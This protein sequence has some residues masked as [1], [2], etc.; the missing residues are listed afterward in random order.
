M[1]AFM[2]SKFLAIV[3]VLIMI[4][5]VNSFVSA[6]QYVIAFSVKTLTNETF[7][8]A[9]ADG[10]K[11]SVEKA[12]HKFVLVTAGGQTAVSTQVNQIEDLIAKKVDGIILNPM[13]SKAVIPAMK[14]AVAKGIKIILVDTPVDRANDS[15]YVCY[16]GTDNYN[17]GVQAGKKMVQVLNG[18]GKVLIVR[19]ANGNMAGDGR[20][21]GFKKGLEGSSIKV[22]SEQV[23]N[24]SNVDAMQAMENMLQANSDVDGVFSA[25]DVMLDGILQAIKDN[26]KTGLKIM[27]VDGS[28][29]G[30][31]LVQSGEITGTMAQFPAFMGESAA[32]LI[33]DILD[34][35]T[36]EKS[37][38]KII[39]S[40]T[41]VFESSNLDEALKMAF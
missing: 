27:S 33:I 10:I 29:K 37:V 2:K 17:A 14:K 4:L 11:K 1:E 15:L 31:D 12:G 9:I 28:R 21:D 5:S 34:K 25:S 13:D 20:V 18:K 26:G 40:G 32:K 19:G 36:D 41:K 23:G 38:K 22:A 6:K 35:K 7:Q 8:A 3:I 30:V 16:I 39:D 24:W